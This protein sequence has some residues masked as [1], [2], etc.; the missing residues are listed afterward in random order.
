MYNRVVVIVVSWLSENKTYTM[1]ASTPCK[2][3]TLAC[4]WHKMNNEWG[5]FLSLYIFLTK[6]QFPTADN[7]KPLFWRWPQSIWSVFIQWDPASLLS[8]L[9]LRYIAN[10]I[11][12][13]IVYLFVYR[14]I[15]R[16]LEIQKYVNVIVSFIGF[17][18]NQN[19][20]FGRFSLILVGLMK[21]DKKGP[22]VKCT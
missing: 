4:F 20:I 13:I 16:K 22:D 7:N 12:I 14:L 2:T 6:L 3:S 1:L 10:Y 5:I 17:R 9:I 21:L 15:R 19:N 18:F 8:N 11:A